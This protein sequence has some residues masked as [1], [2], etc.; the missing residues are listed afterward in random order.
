MRTPVAVGVNLKLITQLAAGAKETSQVPAL[1]KAKSPEIDHDFER[2]NVALPVFFNVTKTVELAVPTTWFGNTIELV[3]KLTFGA[4]GAGVGA[5]AGAGAGAG[6]G[7][8]A[9]AEPN[10]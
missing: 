3:E 6:S 9:E 5:G 7:E 2:S 10:S 4:A 8:G 1:A